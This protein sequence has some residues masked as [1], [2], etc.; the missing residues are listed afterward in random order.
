M[1][2]SFIPCGNNMKAVRTVAGTGASMLLALAIYTVYLFISERNAGNTAEMLFRT[3]MMW[4]PAWNIHLSVGVDGISVAMLMLSS[5]IVF[6]GVFASWHMNPLP[7]DFFMWYS[8]LATGVFGFFISIALFTM[9]LFYEVAL[10]PMYLL[11]GLWGTGR[12]EYAA[13]KLTLML[14][15]GSTFM[16]LGILGIYFSSGYAHQGNFTFNL[17]EIAQQGLPIEAQRLFFPF[18]FWRTWGVVPFP[19]MGSRWSLFCS[20]GSIH[21][22]RWC[23]DEAG[24]VW[25]LPRGYHADARSSS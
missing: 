13:M 9:V 12:K 10:I 25:L 14:M 2:V 5:V 3:D 19:Y 4:Y 11:I 17:L 1:L 21:V 6:T 20:D 18:T 22:A 7:R 15:G 23:P 8:L 24:R 16:I